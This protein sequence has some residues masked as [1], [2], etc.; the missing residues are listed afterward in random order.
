[1]KNINILTD[2]LDR[3][4]PPVPGLPK[5][6]NFPSFY[7]TVTSNGITV[8]VIEDRRLPLVTARFVFKSGAYFDFLHGAEK[9][10]LASVT[11]EMLSKGT[12]L[13]SATKIAEETDF[14]GATLSTGADFDASYVSCYSLTKHF[15]SIFEI[16]TDVI[17]NPAF[18]EEELSRVKEQRL[19]S[20]LAMKDDGDYLAS[21]AY[22]KGIFGSNPLGSSVDG[23]EKSVSGM[24]TEDLVEFYRMHFTPDNLIVAFVGDISPETAVEKLEKCFADVKGEGAEMQNF[25]PP[26]LNEPKI[27]L[28]RK[29]GAVQ[30]SLRVG[31]TS[32]CRNDPDFVNVSVMNTIL[33]GYFTSRI[34]KNLREVHGFTYS[35]RSALSS[36]RYGGDLSVITE[37]KTDITANTIREILK[38]MN[39]LRDV[40]PDSEE[41]QNVKNFISGNFPLQL[42]T[43]NSVA[44]KAINLKLFGLP[45]DYYSTYIR[46]VNQLTSEEIHET[47]AKYLHPGRL[48]MSIAGDVE[49]VSK[50]VSE[51][52]EP[53]I[54]SDNQN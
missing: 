26:P 38:E 25:S 10:G 3:S 4:V 36:H 17:R 32:I 5:D 14:L 37:V 8:L 6:V 27:L 19:N 33:G 11:S 46:K 47:A 7:E 9:S 15:D 30:S 31:H 1:M 34:N 53:E 2:K 51:F 24:T 42:E 48:V 13:R 44:T 20:F 22:K 23:N 50:L 52:G 16:A 43:P 29:E 41:L 28:T 45:E 21:R 35:A 40:A 49:A 18:L 39:M 12:A 54:I